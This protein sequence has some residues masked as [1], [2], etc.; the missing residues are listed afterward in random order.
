MIN[1]KREFKNIPINKI[2]E[3]EGQ[4]DE[5]KNKFDEYNRTKLF[6]LQSNMVSTQGAIFNYFSSTLQN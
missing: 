6:A 5:I 4:G 3:P 2:I 1:N